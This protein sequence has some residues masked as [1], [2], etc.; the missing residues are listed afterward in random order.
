MEKLFLDENFVSKGIPLQICDVFL[1]ELNNSDGAEISYESISILLEPFLK[2]L[3]NSPNI[4]IL[5]RIK[6]KI[7]TPILENNITL[8]EDDKEEEIPDEEKL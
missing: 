7:F 1:N 6:E 4:M 2:T 3:A 5:S 8:E